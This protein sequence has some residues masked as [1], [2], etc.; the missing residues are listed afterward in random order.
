MSSAKRVKPAE[1]LERV[2]QS[3]HHAGQT[4][5][6]LSVQLHRTDRLKALAGD[7]SASQTLQQAALRLI[8]VLRAD[9][10]FAIVSH[11]ALWVFLP[12]VGNESFALLTAQAVRDTLNE[13]FLLSV[14]DEVRGSVQMRP[15]IG[16][17]FLE[18]AAVPADVALRVADDACKTAQRMEDRINTVC[19]NAQAVPRSMED[20]EAKVRQAL[21]ANELEVYF[22]PQ[23]N[24]AS[25]RCVSAE[26][27]VRLPGPA[28]AGIHAGMIASVCEERGLMDTLTRYIINNVM[29]SQMTFKSL[30]IELPVSVNLS[31]TTLGDATF[32]MI[33]EQ[34]AQT[35]G[36]STHMLTLELTEGSIVENEFSAIKFMKRVR[37]MGCELSL[38]DFGTG[39]SSFAYLREFPI[40]ELKIDKLFVS[41]ITERDKD[42]RI[43]QALLELCRAFDLRSVCEGV[44]NA[45]GSQLLHKLGCD[46]GQGYYFS[47]P[48][49]SSE[50]MQW[51]HDFN[52]PT[53]SSA[54]APGRIAA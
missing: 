7:A 44:E 48:M 5:A 34:A 27:L 1:F 43:V 39:Y 2:A 18:A 9:D 17:A 10:L 36:V 13:P 37:S 54:T 19:L 11:E 49:P 24:L 8:Q 21:F 32:P 22:Q 40:S 35:W 23:V 53:P 3:S 20:I 38:D 4:C 6:V 28:G 29:R 30:G 52:A 16:I 25:H 50:F 12:Q 46:L 26:A 41:H 51:V 33:I 47:R 45:E 42:R 14:Q 15:S 31:A